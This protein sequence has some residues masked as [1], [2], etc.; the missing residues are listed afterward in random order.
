MTRRG[1]AKKQLNREHNIFDR[2]YV[3]LCW[4]GV[5]LLCIV[6]ILPFIHAG[7]SSL[8]NP[9]AAERGKVT[10]WP[11]GFQFTAYQ[12]I[13]KMPDF[14]RG[15]GNSFKYTVMSILI[16]IVMIVLMAYPLSRRDFKASKTLTVL[17]TISLLFSAGYIPLY[18]L[19]IKLGLLNTSWALVLPY[20]AG[21]FH[22]FMMRNYIRT[23]IPEELYEAAAIDGCSH[24]L[25]LLKVI[26]PLS[27]P[28]LAVFVIWIAITQWNAYFPA[29]MFI[30]DHKKYPIMAMQWVFFPELLHTFIILASLPLL[31]LYPFTQKFIYNGIRFG[32]IKG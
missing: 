21:A 16:G 18:I 26:V 7:A 3:F 28:I 25:F 30:K 14:W 13:L 22:M 8:S 20:C 24:Y 27:V 23:Y 11:I 29:I 5:I 19:V 9:F 10:L 31:L 1:Y 17:L 15:Y 12:N 4:L 2:I 32:T 6:I